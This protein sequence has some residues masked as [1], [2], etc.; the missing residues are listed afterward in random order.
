MKYRNAT[1]TKASPDSSP[2]PQMTPL[3]KAI[4]SSMRSPPPMNDQE[5]R[6]A[7]SSELVDTSVLRS[8]LEAMQADVER[9][10]AKRKSA[11]GTI[12]EDGEGGFEEVFGTRTCLAMTQK[13]SSL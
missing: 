2:P 7:V 5:L 3:Q 13:L 12:E 4:Y 10:N 11:G 6:S 1:P 9:L 8:D